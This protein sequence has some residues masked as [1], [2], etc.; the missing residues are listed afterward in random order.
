M[1]TSGKVRLSPGDKEVAV[2]GLKDMFAQVRD[3]A[4]LAGFLFGVA[5][6]SGWAR[7]W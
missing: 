7:A 5:L 6:L 1:L 2:T 3:L 4:L